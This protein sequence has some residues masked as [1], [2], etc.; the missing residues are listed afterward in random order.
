MPQPCPCCGYL[1]PFH[2]TGCPLESYTR[3]LVRLG[4]PAQRQR[5]DGQEGRLGFRGWTVIIG[6]FAAIGGAFAW[7]GIDA[8]G[9]QIIELEA[10]LAAQKAA[11]ASLDTKLREACAN[12]PYG[13]FRA[14]TGPYVGF[15]H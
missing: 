5:G 3:Y 8:Q 11:T 1:A 14:L 10:A 12:G 6:I 7:V 9:K 2:A 13:T 15:G 4:R